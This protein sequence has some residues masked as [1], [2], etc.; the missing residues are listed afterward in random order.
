M[1]LI[2]QFKINTKSG[3]NKNHLTNQVI[4]IMRTVFLRPEGE[5]PY[6]PPPFTLHRTKKEPAGQAATD[7]AKLHRPRKFFLAAPSNVLRLCVSGCA[8]RI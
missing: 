2:P 7:K 1:K 8:Y 3:R 5:K 6:Y 4:S